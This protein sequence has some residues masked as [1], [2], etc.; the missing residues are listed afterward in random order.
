MGLA[1]SL[2]R[3]PLPSRI[4]E[5]PR[6]YPSRRPELTALYRLFDSLFEDYLRAHEE[7]FE[8]KDERE[9]LARYV[10]RPPLPDARVREGPDGRLLVRAGA[11]EVAFS[12][13][14]LVH[15]LVEQIPDR[16]HHLV[17]HYG[18][19]ANRARKLHRPAEGLRRIEHR[20]QE[21]RAGAYRERRAES[22]WS[23]GEL[24]GRRRHAGHGDRR[25]HAPVLEDHAESHR[26]PALPADTAVCRSRTEGASV[27][28][29]S[30][31][32]TGKCLDGGGT[33]QSHRTGLLRVRGRASS[34]SP[35][36][37]SPP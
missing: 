30:S 33:G 10:A 34:P 3:S 23:E 29:R 15:A 5:G 32:V 19:Y 28:A 18:A 1:L 26:L 7:R 12:P 37:A 6:A 13:L 14:D 17:R 8:P 27:C 25:R 36:P 24:P 22:V 35:V 21:L 4:R 31:S 20:D 11:S 9:R 16:G 2:P